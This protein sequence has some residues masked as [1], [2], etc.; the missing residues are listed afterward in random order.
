MVAELLLDLFNT[1]IQDSLDSDFTIYPRTGFE[2]PEDSEQHRRYLIG[3]FGCLPGALLLS[4]NQ[5]GGVLGAL[6]VYAG[7]SS[8]LLFGRPGEVNCLLLLRL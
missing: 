4:G 7:D 2:D 8:L 6:Q 5:P 1:P 3:E